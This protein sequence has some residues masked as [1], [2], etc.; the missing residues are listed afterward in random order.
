MITT[1][2]SYNSKEAKGAHRLHLNENGCLDKEGFIHSLRDELGNLGLYPDPQCLALKESL[3]KHHKIETTN[4][5]IGNGLDEV[6][7]LLST[8]YLSRGDTILTSEMTFPGYELS[9]KAHKADSIKV[10]MYQHGTQPSLYGNYLEDSTKLAYLC[11]PHNPCGTIQDKATVI[12]L[13]ERMREK[14]VLAIID[15][16]YIQ[17][18]DESVYSVVD[19]VNEYDNL[20]V[21]RSFS[22][23]HGL[24]SVRVGYAIASKKVI[25]ELDNIACALPFRVNRLAQ[26]A[27]KRCIES[28]T[29]IQESV[30]GAQERV[31]NMYRFLTGLGVPAVKSVTNFL[32]VQ[33]DAF[34]SDILSYL[35]KQ[36]ISVRDCGCFGLPGYIRVSFASEADCKVF[37]SAIEAYAMQGSEMSM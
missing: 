29:Y 28:K 20:V 17:F 34:G 4:L 23:S 13:I 24:A 19:L 8:A 11:N 27:A 36:G 1:L 7:F 33:I 30:S 5:F 14:N 37:K 9:A 18:S 32:L 2:E 15:E 25:S 3:A 10:P 16:A 6:V 21:L 12:D 26:V 35:D 31:S 22:K